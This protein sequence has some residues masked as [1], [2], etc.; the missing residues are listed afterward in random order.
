MVRLV[1]ISN[2]EYIAYDADTKVNR[3]GAIELLGA[4]HIGFGAVAEV[5]D[6]DAAGAGKARQ[7]GGQQLGEGGVGC[8]ALRKNLPIQKHAGRGNRQQMPE[9]GGPFSP[10][11]PSHYAGARWPLQHHDRLG[12]S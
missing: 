11:A 9:H 2:K 4:V 1:K 10:D 3:A 8:C 7:L 6:V 5:V 12:A